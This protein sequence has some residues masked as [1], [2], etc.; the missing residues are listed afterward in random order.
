MWKQ[1]HT[2]Q[3][4][5]SYLRSVI[6]KEGSKPSFFVV[7]LPQNVLKPHKM[8]TSECRTGRQIT[9]SGNAHKQGVFFILAPFYGL[10][11]CFGFFL[12]GTFYSIYFHIF[13]HVFATFF[14]GDSNHVHSHQILRHKL[15]RIPLRALFNSII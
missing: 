5:M 3:R 11:R 1:S 10:F 4:K 12:F 7:F 9:I 15:A 2:L 14:S 13:C 6:I 8:A